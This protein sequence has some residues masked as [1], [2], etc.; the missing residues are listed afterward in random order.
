VTLGKCSNLHFAK[1]QVAERYNRNGW[2]ASA[3]DALS[4]ALLMGKKDVVDQ[5]LTHIATIDFSKTATPDPSQ[6]S[7]FETTVS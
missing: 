1:L 3:A 2:G 5:I 7:L 4:T 6:V